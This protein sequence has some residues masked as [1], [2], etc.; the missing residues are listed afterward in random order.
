ML[1]VALLP[2][3]KTPHCIGLL[4]QILLGVDSLVSLIQVNS[5][6]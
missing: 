5:I 2:A 3:V 4:L 6:T 1:Q